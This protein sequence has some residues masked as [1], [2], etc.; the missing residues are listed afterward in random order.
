MAWAK[1]HAAMPVNEVTCIRSV[2]EQDDPHT[3]EQLLP[4]VYD[5]L[6]EAGRGEARPGK[7][8]ADAPGHGPGARGLPA[9]GRRG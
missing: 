7:P 2:M 1:G 3:A 5:E 6:Q 8:R 4:L 9:A